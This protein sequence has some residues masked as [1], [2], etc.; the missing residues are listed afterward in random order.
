[1]IRY[2]GR[3]YGTAAH[4]RNDA[5]ARRAAATGGGPCAT[6][7]KPFYTHVCLSCS[8][9][10]QTPGPGCINCRRTGMDQT[11]CLPP[12]STMRTVYNLAAWLRAQLDAREREI[13]ERHRRTCGHD[14]VGADWP[15]NCD[16]HVSFSLAEVDVKR[17]ILDLHAPEQSGYKYT[18]PDTRV[19]N[20]RCSVCHDIPEDVDYDNP[21]YAVEFPCPTL[22]LL[23]LP[24]A[25]RPGYRDEWRP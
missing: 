14:E 15:C 9:D 21:P 19:P 8:P 17:R 16:D 25:T 13:R 22:R 2:A 24:C 20:M 7:G 1:M 4:A 10:A 12:A 23:A 18:D 6:C 11:P 5:L 3:E